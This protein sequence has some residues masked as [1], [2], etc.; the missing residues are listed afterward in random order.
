[1]SFGWGLRKI[2]TLLW[3][4]LAVRYKNAF[5]SDVTE[6]TVPFRNIYISS[7][8]FTCSYGYYSSPSL[9]WNAIYGFFIY[10]FFSSYEKLSGMFH[11][12]FRGIWIRTYIIF[13]SLLMAHF[14]TNLCAPVKP[15]ATP[16]TD[17]YDWQC[18]HGKMNS[19]NLISLQCDDKSAKKGNAGTDGTSF[20]Q[21]DQ[22]QENWRFMFWLLL[23]VYISSKGIVKC[24][25]VIVL[26]LTQLF[27][28]I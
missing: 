9:F 15:Y 26:L 14:Y 4:S 21:G 18:N 8:A 17:V 13:L 2:I 23:S 5:P 20:E 28:Y 1:M 27:S 25:M 24:V 11:C 19:N 22:C 10:V 7:V 6:V 12:D 16:A 3:V